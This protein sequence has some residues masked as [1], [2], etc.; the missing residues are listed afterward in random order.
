MGRRWSIWLGEWR[1]PPP[2]GRK[3][4]AK[5]LSNMSFATTEDRLTSEVVRLFEECPQLSGAVIANSD[6]LVLASQGTLFKESAAAVATHLI[7]EM[8]SCMKIM[9]QGVVTEAMIWTAKGPWYVTRIGEANNILALGGT[10]EMQAGML[11]HM[12]FLAS[13]RFAACL[14]EVGE[15]V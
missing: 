10:Q 1:G 5:V 8:D 3:Q 7:A 9:D 4:G 2:L 6:G 14:A 13:G 15:L 11:R 12:A